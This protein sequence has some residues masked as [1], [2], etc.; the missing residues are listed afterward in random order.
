MPSSYTQM[1]L[2]EAGNMRWT[3]VLLLSRDAP[4]LKFGRSRKLNFMDVIIM[5]V[6]RLLGKRQSGYCAQHP[7]VGRVKGRVNK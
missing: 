6:Q 1:E 7:S 5:G 4:V 3:S 2:G